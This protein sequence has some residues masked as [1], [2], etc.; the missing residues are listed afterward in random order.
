M[1]IALEGIL[2]TTCCGG[3]RGV[4]DDPEVT[5]EAFLGVFCASDATLVTASGFAVASGGGNG[6]IEIPVTDA[7]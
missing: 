3:V 5:I 1:Y 7:V 6:E 2:G 4:V